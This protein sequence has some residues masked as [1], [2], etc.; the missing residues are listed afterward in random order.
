MNS[1]WYYRKKWTK[2]VVLFVAEG[3]KVGTHC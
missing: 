1:L 2:A 3:K